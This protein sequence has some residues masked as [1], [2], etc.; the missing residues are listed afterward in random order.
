MSA[1][2]GRA[3]PGWWFYAPLVASFAPPTAALVW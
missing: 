1:P 2:A 3:P